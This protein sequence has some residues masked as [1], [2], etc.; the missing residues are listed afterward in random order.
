MITKTILKENKEAIKTIEKTEIYEA[1]KN[2]NFGK[3][4][5]N[6]NVELAG[7]Y[8]TTVEVKIQKNKKGQIITTINRTE[9]VKGLRN[10]RKVINGGTIMKNTIKYYEVHE[11]PITPEN[12]YK[13][14]KTMEYEQLYKY[15][16]LLNKD[17]LE[18]IV[19]DY[20]VETTTQMLAHQILEEK[21]N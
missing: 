15:F 11:I 4:E 9:E 14:I 12:I 6:I 10:A 16:Q 13:N 18:T 8:I 17:A 21:Y 3:M 7:V 2:K 19:V 1:I 20:R 5:F